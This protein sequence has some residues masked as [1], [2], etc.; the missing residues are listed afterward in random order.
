MSE[1]R[2]SEGRMP[3]FNESICRK[4]ETYIISIKPPTYF[5]IMRWVVFQI[6]KC[7]PTKYFNN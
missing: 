6:M 3:E 5:Q 2:P 1:F 4:G 7:N